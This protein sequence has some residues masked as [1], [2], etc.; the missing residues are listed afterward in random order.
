MGL[1]PLMKISEQK[2][3][4]RYIH[5]IILCTI[6]YRFEK[7][8]RIITPK[9]TSKVVLVTHRSVDPINRGVVRHCPNIRGSCPP[10]SYP[11]C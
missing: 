2:R 5:L 10:F 3:Q 9:K 8:N 4:L 1:N 11:K 6:K 7:V